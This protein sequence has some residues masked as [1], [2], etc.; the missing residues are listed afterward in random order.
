[1]SSLAK[2]TNLKEIAIENNPV[3]LGGDCVSFLVSYLPNLTSL[4]G[5]QITDHVRKAAMAW[6]HNKELS[7]TTFM[8][9]TTDVCSNIRRE[10]VISNARTNWEL[11]RSQTKCLTQTTTFFKESKDIDLVITS[12]DMNLDKRR[13]L[14]RSQS[15]DTDNTSSSNSDL[16]LPPILVPMINNL[17]KLESRKILDNDLVSTGANVDSSEESLPSSSVDGS[18]DDDK[19]VVL[20]IVLSR[21]MSTEPELKITQSNLCDN[22]STI[23]TGNSSTTSGHNT[24]SSCGESV[25]SQASHADT[26]RSRPSERS[27]KS[28]V[29][30]RTINHRLNYRAATAKP[31]L[32][33]SSSPIPLSSKDREQ[34]SDYLAEICGRHLNIFGHGA[35]RYIDR[36]WNIDKA[37]DVNTVKFTY[38]NFNGIPSMLTKLKSRFPNAENFIFRETNINCLG[39]LNALAEIQGIYSLEI[40]KEGNAIIEKDWR[41]YAIFRLSHWG[42]KIINGV[43]IM[44]DDVIRANEDY[45]SLSDLVS[46]SLPD[47]LLQP[48]LQRLQIDNS[49][50]LLNA[51]QWLLTADPALRSVVSKEALQWHRGAIPQVILMIFCVF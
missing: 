1:M 16:R 2:A 8:D 48:L 34:G 3:S 50:S 27:I 15:Q 43:E 30:K 5:M 11:L 17:E 49:D 45:Q 18:S 40:E 51:K 37:H 7:N 24:L 9:L 14:R 36:P 20:P 21:V 22:G 28:A 6:R 46:W 12:T 42:L 10:E 32:K 31:K 41:D 38:V 4:S 23:S 13:L 44:E 47:T 33:K 25:C 35:L 26:I 19:K 29:T 39:Q